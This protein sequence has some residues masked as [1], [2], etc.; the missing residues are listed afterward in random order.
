MTCKYEFDSGEPTAKEVH[1]RLWRESINRVLAAAVLVA[2]DK[3][4]E[5]CGTVIALR[6]AL[7]YFREFK[8][9]TGVQNP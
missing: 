1:W 7:D 2:A 8:T 5:S 3:T 6:H 4:I 9:K